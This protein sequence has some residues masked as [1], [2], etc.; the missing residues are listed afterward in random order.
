MVDFHKRLDGYG[1]TTAHILY[2]VPDHL[3]L[4]QT[5]V[6]QHDDLFPEFPELCVFLKFWKEKLDGPLHS[7]QIS[8]SKLLKAQAFNCIDG[9]F[10]LH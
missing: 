6:W 7:V 3:W 10:R 2:R 9:E 8:H 5:F 4:L 1:M